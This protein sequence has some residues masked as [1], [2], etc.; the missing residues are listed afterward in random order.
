MITTHNDA[1]RNIQY[2]NKFV[3]KNGRDE[4]TYIFVVNVSTHKGCSFIKKHK[5]C[6][7]YL[8]WT[9]QLSESFPLCEFST[10]CA[11]NN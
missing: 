4:L 10:N 2:D 8:K 3:S 5:Q 1:E 7:S 6:T 11:L 9:K